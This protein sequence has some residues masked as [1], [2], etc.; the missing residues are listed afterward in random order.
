MVK[1]WLSGITCDI[2]NVCLKSKLINIFFAE[3]MK[4]VQAWE[5][6]KLCYD[7]IVNMSLVNVLFINTVIVSK[8]VV[9]SLLALTMTGQFPYTICIVEIPMKWKI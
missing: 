8:S 6:L 3:E 2:R 4:G 9:A 7:I 5:I 1:V